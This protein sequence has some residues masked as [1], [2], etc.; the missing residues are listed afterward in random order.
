MKAVYGYEFVRGA[1]AL[2]DLK[3]NAQRRYVLSEPVGIRVF[4][5]SGIFMANTETGFIFDGRSGPRIAD[6]L[7]PNLGT[8]EERTAF[9]LHDC[10]AYAQSLGFAETNLLLKYF[11]RDMCAYSNFM[12]ELV[13][14][15]VSISKKWYGFP[16][17]PDDPWYCNI[18]KVTTKWQNAKE[19]TC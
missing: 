19:G 5:D 13:R 4:T 12:S 10:A 14:K 8:L 15:A 9:F 7:V 2:F 11:L 3:E 1:N 16:Q 6:L 17:S 18:G